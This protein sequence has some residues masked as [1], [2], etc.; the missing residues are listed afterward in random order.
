MS[1]RIRLQNR[2]GRSIATLPVCALLAVGLWWLPQGAYSHDSLVSLLLMALTAYIVAET[3]NTNMLIRTRSRMIASVWVF[4]S[5]F[6]GL[7]HPFSPAMLAAFCL[8]VSYYLLF[9]TYQQP[10]PVVDVFHTFFMLALG[11]LVCPRMVFFVPL[12]FW[13][14][15]VFMRALTLRTFFAAL[16]GLVLP[17]W[18]W[19][20]WLL[21]TDNP[22]P[23][24]A[25][26]ADLRSIVW[27]WQ[28]KGLPDVLHSLPSLVFLSLALF[29]LWTGVSYLL[30]S[31]DDKIRTRMMFY[32]YALQTLA[33][34]LLAVLGY[35]EA[36]VSALLPLLLLSASPLLA[37]Y[38]TLSSTWTSL[39]VF[40][41][42]VLAALFVGFCTLF[43]E[44]MSLVFH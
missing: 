1:R 18:F 8:S 20:G 28:Q 43:P 42:F 40:V 41:L 34:I 24:L 11:S 23:F 17:F 44:A 26:L 4:A 7:L 36:G 39:A 22:A 30:H 31:Y 19:G 32:V 12:F 25:W 14:L 10:Q 3:N 35:S 21:W 16:V 33:I 37:H 13:H 15:S 27:I 2:I 38:F 29:A 5:A 9:R 6:V